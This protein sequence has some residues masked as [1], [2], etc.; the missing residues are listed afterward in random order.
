MKKKR[1]LTDIERIDILWDKIK[2]LGF[3]GEVS[4]TSEERLF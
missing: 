4:I 3:N 2:S 1:K